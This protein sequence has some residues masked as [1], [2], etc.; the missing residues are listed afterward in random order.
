MQMHAATR[1]SGNVAIIDLSGGI[2]IAGGVG[3]LR[4]KI[5]ELM[6]AGQKNVLLNLKEITYLDSAGMGELVGACT[7]LRNQGGDLRL[8]HPQERVSKLLKMTKLSMIF[9]IFDD[10]PA[11]VASFQ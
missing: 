9:R 2:T 11:A 8:V 7:T 3:L 6:T 5:K 10:E 4:N 1:H